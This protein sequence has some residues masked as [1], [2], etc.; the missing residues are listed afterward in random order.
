MRRRVATVLSVLPVLFTTTLLAQESRDPV[1]LKDWP[2]P[3]EQIRAKVMEREPRLIA[4][5]SLHPSVNAVPSAASHFI[6]VVPCRV[7]DTR[8]A[9]GPYGG[10]KLVGGASRSFVIPSGPCAGIPV[11]VAYSLTLTVHEPA[12]NDGLLKAYP[13]RP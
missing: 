8:N 10:P 6:T 3:F 12:A 7:V 1:P 13:T 5:R 4:E 11:A 9:N 2:V